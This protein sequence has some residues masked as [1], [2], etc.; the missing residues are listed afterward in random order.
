M[1][2]QD[3]IARGAMWHGARVTDMEAGY[4]EVND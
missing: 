2:S 3:R 4:D 1:R